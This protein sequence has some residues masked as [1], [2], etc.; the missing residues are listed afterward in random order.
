MARMTHPPGNTDEITDI[1]NFSKGIDLRM[2]NSIQDVVGPRGFRSGQE[3]D[4]G[5][6]V[7]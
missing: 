5:E 4:S 7:S 1:Q 3:R 2:N 6:G